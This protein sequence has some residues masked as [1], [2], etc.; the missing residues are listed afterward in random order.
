MISPHKPFSSTTPLN[1]LTSDPY[2]TNTSFRVGL[3]ERKEGRD[4]QR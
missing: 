2:P 1:Q 4:E 3:G